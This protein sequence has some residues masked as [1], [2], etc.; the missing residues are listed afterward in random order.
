MVDRLLEIYPVSDFA[1]FD[2][3]L[4]LNFLLLGS[5]EAA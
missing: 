1:I 5:Q 2:Y 3:L 4:M